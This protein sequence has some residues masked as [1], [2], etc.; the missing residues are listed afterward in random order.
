MP[1]PGGGA[2]ATVLGSTLAMPIDAAFAGAIT[3]TGAVSTVLTE[4]GGAISKRGRGGS[5]AGAR[6]GAASAVSLET[7]P[8]ATPG[9]PRIGAGVA[10][11]APEVGASGACE[12]RDGGS[13]TPA[14][15]EIPLPVSSAEETRSQT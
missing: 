11:A 12:R 5:A 6:R 14:L 2:T 8:A 1:A 4:A 3:L 10:L 15:W 13:S 9:L 7:A